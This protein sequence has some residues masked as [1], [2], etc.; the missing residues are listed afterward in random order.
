MKNQ[1]QPFP[2]LLA[3]VLAAAPIAI[4]GGYVFEQLSGGGRNALFTLLTFVLWGPGM[5]GSLIAGP[6]A[7]YL[8]RRDRPRYTTPWNVGLVVVNLLPLLGLVALVLIVMFG[9]V[10]I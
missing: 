3:F 4:I 5:L 9:S 2:P 8:M 7:L 6:I 10:H 1:P